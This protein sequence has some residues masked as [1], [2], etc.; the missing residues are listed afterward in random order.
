[1]VLKDAPDRF[2]LTANAATGFDQT[3]LN[4][5]FEQFNSSVINPNSPAQIY[6]PSYVAKISDFPTGNIEYK[7]VA[8]PPN[9]FGGFTIGDRFFGGRFGILA[10]ASYQNVYSATSGFWDRQQQQPNYSPAPNTPLWDYVSNRYYS[11]QQTRTAG[12]LKMDYIFNP[13]HKISFYTV[14]TEMKEVR[15]RIEQDTD[16]SLANSELDPHYQSKVSYQHILNITLKGKDTLAH[17]LLLDWTGSY[18]RAWANTPDWDDISLLGSVGSPLVYFSNLSRVWMQNTDQDFSGY[19]NLTYDFDL[20]GQKIELKTGAMNRDKTRNAYYNEYDFPAT[21][22]KVPY[23][24]I[25]TTLNS[26]NP[27]LVD[28]NDG[29]GSPQ[30]SDTYYVGEDIMAYYG[31]AK[32][33]LFSKLELLGG[34]RIENTSQAYVDGESIQ[35]PAQNGTKQYSDYLPSVEVKYLLTDKQAIHASYFSS[36]SRPSFID[37]VPY[38]LS[39][40]EFTQIGNPYLKHTTANNYDLRYEFFPKPEDQVLVGVFYKQIYNP[41]EE[42]IVPGNGPSAVFEKPINIGG[43][44]NPAINYGFEFA[45]AKYIKHFGVTANYTYTHSRIT[46]NE[47]LYGYAPGTLTIT[48]TIVP[49]TRPMQGQTDN[50]ANLSFV[51]KEPK[52]GFEAQISAVYTGKSIADI[53]QFYELEYWQMPM[54]TIGFSFQKR[55]SKKINLS[56]YGKANNILNTPLVEYVRSHLCNHISNYRL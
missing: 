11:D 10:S 2:Y 47:I 43:D 14:Y 41:I 34:M 4:R 39:G 45:V 51:Y 30:S 40:D 35:I 55:L 22:L 16:N 46:V 21:P 25:S 54:T 26:T 7:D 31:M 48:R 5:G 37:I 36:I 8:A 27:P 9:T 20:F 32:I 29:L 44:S 50:V 33:K 6:G 52:I 12:H 24:N 28:F 1:L 49:E 53:S 15:S 42:A 19:I 3:L 38:Q 56:L 13:K 18:A 23:T 17:N